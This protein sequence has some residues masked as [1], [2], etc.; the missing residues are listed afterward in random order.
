LNVVDDLG[1]VLA[2]VSDPTRRAIIARLARGPACVT[3]LATPFPMSL[4]AVSKHIKVLEKAGMVRRA[5]RGREHTLEL[6]AAPLEHV[7]RWAHRY[8]RFWAERL[9]R[10]EA[11]FAGRT[12]RRL[13]AGTG[14]SI[15][16]AR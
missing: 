15:G 11:H 13:T 4:N 2:A 1:R 5:R 6:D 8:E 14:R 3:E 10:L 9:D 12:A 16:G 7:A